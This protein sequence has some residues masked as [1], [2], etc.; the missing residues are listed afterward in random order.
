MKK[1]LFLLIITCALLSAQ[2]IG[3][4]YLIITHDNFYNAVQPL[5][6]WKHKKGLRTKVV[7]LSETGSSSYQIRNYITNAYNSW[8]VQPEY[9]LL[10]GAPNY[11]PF[12]QIG[13]TY[14][15][16]YYTNITGTIY[17]EILSGRLTVHST[18]EAQTVV[19]KIMLYERTPDITD[20]TW[21]TSAALI[22]RLDWDSDDS[23][24][25]SDTY[26]AA[27]LMINNGYTI[28]DT[29]SNYYG[30]N[31]SHV[32]SAINSGRSILMYRGSGV[33]NWYSPFNVN[34][35]QT[36]NGNKLPIVLS[37]TCRT[38][39]TGSTPATA[40]RWLLTGTTTS[41]RGGVG[42]FAT[43]TTVIGQAY[44][45]SAVAKGFFDAV[46]IDNK[47]TF[48]EACEAGRVRVYQMYLYQGGGDEYYGFTTLGDPAM[49]LWTDC[50][51][52][53]DV[54]HDSSLYVGDDTLDVHVEHA[55]MPVESAF[56]CIVLDSTI[57]ETGYTDE[58]GNIGFAVTLPH[59][60]DM[61]VTVT[62][63][64]LYPY[65]GT[66][67]V[68]LGIEEDNQVLSPRTSVSML[69]VSPNPF[70]KTIKI[71]MNPGKDFTRAELYICDI[72]GARV[73]TFIPGEAIDPH[74]ENIDWDGTDDSGRQ[75]PPGIYFIQGRLYQATGS[76]ALTTTRK[77]IKLK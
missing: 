15:D 54:T 21:F 3:A 48:G 45:R 18:T 16:N 75:V 47:R 70:F 60:G 62:G 73:K 69:K 8:P 7:K 13:W 17:N 20:S 49:E 19:N 43:T 31:T 46:F 71:T 51:K 56:V 37:V 32:L 36:Q 25:W 10:V 24:Y 41:P 27:D 33:N 67:E 35:D 28:I 9:L 6:E 12:E 52:V 2:E 26:H 5:A 53:L 58:L 68:I 42:Y 76:D 1:Y 14:S 30:H 4:R 38:I 29:I 50:P 22:A 55:E 61:D 64:N 39:G 59:Q 57:Y 66:V 72:T 34:P 65:E 77:I 44:L 40:E 11:L 63:K 74:S 23:I